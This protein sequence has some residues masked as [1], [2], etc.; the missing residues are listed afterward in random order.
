[1][2]LQRESMRDRVKNY[3]LDRIV[4][5][6]YKPGDRLV[7]LQIAK[8]LNTSQAPVREALRELEAMRLIESEA[9]RGTRVRKITLK[10]LRESHQVAG[11][12]ESLAGRLAASAFK[13]NPEELLSLHKQCIAAVKAKDVKK[14]VECN[15]A[16]H[17]LIVEKSGNQVLL[18]TWDSLSFDVL[19]RIN[20]EWFTPKSFGDNMKKMKKIAI[21]EHQA[22]VD[23]LVAGDGIKAGELLRKHT[24]ETFAYLS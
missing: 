20:I 24:A 13:D 10:E 3:L 21:E 2:V 18:Q 6:T 22:I 4:D 16:F 11:E 8:E 17:R 5:G 9:Y 14:L 15:T 7:E 19:V 1:M 12:L 23:A